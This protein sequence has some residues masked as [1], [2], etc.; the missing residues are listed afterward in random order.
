MKKKI[1]CLFLALMMI[2]PLIGMSACS[3]DSGEISE[4]DKERS[5]MT[6][7]L[8][9][10]C[11]D[12]TTEDSIA[13]VQQAL[14]E[15]CE[16]KYSTHLV[17]HFV[18]SNEYETAVL[19]RF[20]EIEEEKVRQELE[21]I[22]KRNQTDDGGKSEEKKS[23][24]TEAAIVTETDEYGLP[25]VVYPEV[26]A[27]QMDLFLIRGEENYIS[28]IEMEQLSTLDEVLIEGDPKLMKTFIY[29]T[30][31]TYAKYDDSLYA[32]PNNRALGEYTYL[33][34]NKACVETVKANGVNVDLENIN[35]V[36][37]ILSFAEAVGRYCS[38]YTP[39]RGAF[40]YSGI[41]FWDA[42]N[43]GNFSLIASNITG[44]ATP[45]N[46]FALDSFTTTFYA[47]KYLSE[48]GLV[49]DGSA[50]FGKFAIATVKGKADMMA[51]YGEDYYFIPL[52]APDVTSEE[53]CQYMIGINPNTRDMT[54]ASEILTLINTNQTFRTILQYGVEG[55]HWKYT[56]D[57]K[58]TITRLDNSYNMKLEETGNTYITF[59]DYGVSKDFWSYSKTQNLDSAVSQLY[60]F[61]DS[62]ASVIKEVNDDITSL[63]NKITQKTNDISKYEAELKGFSGTDEEKKDLQDKLKAAQK[64]KD[65]AQR[66][67]E[68]TQLI[69][70]WL[71]NFGKDTN[72][73]YASIQKMSAGEF[74]SSIDSLRTK[75][76]ELL[77]ASY[78]LYREDEENPFTIY[79]LTEDTTIKPDKTYYL[80]SG[81]NYYQVFSPTVGTKI[82]PNSYY[83]AQ[84]VSSS[85]SFV[86]KFVSFISE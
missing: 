33:L 2:L 51:D 57:S 58:T 78:L 76:D 3:P 35:D 32:I 72:D 12:G 47:N 8:W 40:D 67:M 17:L 16:N 24:D 86:E 48:K 28:Y 27:D 53:V 60:R 9:L 21:S 68:E 71:G 83:E 64:D 22:A 54:R 31:F 38:G 69:A 61:P 41:R 43:S 42:T 37:D 23:A 59:P 26:R 14:N 62:V 75:V 25:V 10:P 81:K 29:P 44:D 15:I 85:Y 19:N 30:F 11:Y 6:V 4:S 34:I 79:N 77:N 49:G 82:E 52:S 56:D 84:I 1:T 7:D 39:V 36:S 18:P 13:L 70:S 74:Q 73:I 80:K 66:S 5:S 63:R 55:I 45:T 65:S 46:V 20:D 50:A